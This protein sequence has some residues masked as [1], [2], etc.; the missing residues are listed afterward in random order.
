MI[1]IQFEAFHDIV[2]GH[3]FPILLTNPQ[4]FDRALIALSKHVQINIMTFGAAELI[5]SHY[6][7]TS[8]MITV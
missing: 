4:V 2:P 8:Q 7:S 5:L 6:D 3:F 1:A